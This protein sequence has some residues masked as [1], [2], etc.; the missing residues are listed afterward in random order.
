VNQEEK[1]KREADE[2]AKENP[3]AVFLVVV[4]LFGKVS[5]M[6]FQ[7]KG[8]SLEKARSHEHHEHASKTR[9]GQRRSTGVGSRERESNT[10][11][12]RGHCTTHNR[13]RV[14]PS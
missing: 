9:P 6:A 7:A 12:R 13:G 1:S 5:G 10:S 8:E 3:F 2:D 11:R 14:S 4:T